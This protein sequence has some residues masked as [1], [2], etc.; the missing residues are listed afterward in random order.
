MAIQIGTV[1]DGKYE[2][3]KQIGKGGMSTVYLAMDKRLNKQWA[4]KEISRHGIG[5]NN[6]E[7]ENSARDAEMIKN[8]DH[9]AIP[10]IVGII[11][12]K[13]D[14][15]IY[16]VMD[17]VE[18]DSL[19]KVLKE[20]GAVPQ[21]RVIDWAKQICDAFIYLHS[22]KPPIIYRDM[23]PGNVMLKP[24]GNI[25]IIDFGIA[26][27]FKEQNLADTTILGTRG[28]APPEQYGGK[29]DPRSDIYAL[30]MTLHH[31]LT[32]ID[33]RPADYVYAPIR[34]WN[35]ELSAG[36]ERVIEKC[37][38]PDP[39]DRYQNCSELLYALDHY[40]EEDVDFKKKQKAQLS[41][42]VIS[43][44]LAVIM[45][46]VGVFGQLME[47]RVNNNDYSALVTEIKSMT[48]MDEINDKCVQAIN[49]T[50][51]G[52]EYDA[53]QEFVNAAERQESLG[54]PE[55]YN[56]LQNCFTNN[57]TDTSSKGRIPNSITGENAATIDNSEA[58]LQ[59]AYNLGRV[60]FAYYKEYTEKEED[61][62][63]V[64][65]PNEN[66]APKAR[67]QKALP[68]FAYVVNSGMTNS[69]YYDICLSYY[70]FCKIVGEGKG[71]STKEDLELL[72]ESINIC[73]DNDLDSAKV[74]TNNDGAKRIS[75][76]K[77]TIYY[78]FG[79]VIEDKAKAFAIKGIDKQEV[80][81]TLEKIQSKALAVGDGT[82]DDAETVKSDINNRYNSWVSLIDGMYSNNVINSGKEG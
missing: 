9:P 41:Y 78:G 77:L 73:C 46:F 4:V 66:T 63:A 29:T 6:E 42:F 68:Y 72:L 69:D 24:E 40:E 75:Y 5:K 55:S 65:I 61:G 64:Q 27:E 22:Q 15:Y 82:D 49:L 67:A 38:S 26:R 3:L 19:D 8:L 79:S 14:D 2:I 56:A 18:G 43:S 11:D 17:Y 48:N 32:G 81:D 52:K 71:E 23:K 51:M 57:F 53:Y 30:G 76:I 36:L 44:V 7:V 16:V 20:Y 28:Y 59:L 34:Q 58:C 45:L 12:N 25:K 35:P 1:L 31:L 10:T 74:Q 70:R 80:L 39:K 33:P 50:D 37:V 21:E 47:T 60:T 13:D 62:K 54:S